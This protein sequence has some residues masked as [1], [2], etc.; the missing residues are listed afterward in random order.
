MHSEIAKIQESAL[1]RP[2]YCFD[3]TYNFRPAEISM[4]NISRKLASFASCSRELHLTERTTR[5]IRANI[6]IRVN[7][8][9]KTTTRMFARIVRRR[10]RR[11][12]VR[13]QANASLPASSVQYF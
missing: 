3:F 11:R 2:A 6:R 12:G 7:T 10:R 5:T 8:Q 1:F 9:A 13:A 4:L